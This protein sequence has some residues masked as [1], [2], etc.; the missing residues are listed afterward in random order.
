MASRGCC[1]PWTQHAVAC[2]AWIMLVHARTPRA[3]AF[4]DLGE[5]TVKEAHFVNDLLDLVDR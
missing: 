1:D 5:C 3:H 2:P 4:P